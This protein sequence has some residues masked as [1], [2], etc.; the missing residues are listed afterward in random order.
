MDKNN[1][2]ESVCPPSAEGMASLSKEDCGENGSVA[3]AGAELTGMSQVDIDYFAKVQ[4]RVAMVESAEVVPKSKKLLK[5][6]LDV[7]SEIGKRQILA[8]V[9]QFY[10]PETLIGRKIVIVANLKPAI[11]MGIESQGMLLA[12]SNADGSM[13]NIVDPGQNLP[14]GSVVR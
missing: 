7:G 8:G 14:A 12:S 2:S 9:A 11:L 13:L 4:L 10:S 6:Q 3:P 1:T 5:L